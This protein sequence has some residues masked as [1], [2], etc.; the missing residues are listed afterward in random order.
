MISIKEQV[1]TISK[2]IR[3]MV[4]GL[5]EIPNESFKVAMGTF[6]VWNESKGICFGC[7]AT[8]TI[9]QIASKR[10]EGK[11]I[12]WTYS[13]AEYL[14]FDSKE[15]DEFE[16]MIN[17]IRQGYFSVQVTSFYNLNCTVF[18]ELEFDEE[19][20]CLSS[21]FEEDDLVQ[22]ENFATILEAAGL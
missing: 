3:L 13:R 19:L 14:S 1:P 10:F 11:E 18:Q 8:C 5:R 6:G 21:N 15:L 22:Y 20:P 16:R 2:A 12:D 17:E 9:Q 4:T 7:A